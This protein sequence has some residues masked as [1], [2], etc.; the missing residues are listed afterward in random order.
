M[1]IKSRVNILTGAG[2]SERTIYMDQ[3]RDF[4]AQILSLY[5]CT[6]LK[7]GSRS[8][9]MNTLFSELKTLWSTTSA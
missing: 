3:M 5:F 1:G 2:Q 6:I 4:Q 7:D 9:Q 8:D